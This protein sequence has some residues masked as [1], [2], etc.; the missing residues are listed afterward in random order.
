MPTQQFFEL[1]HGEDIIMCKDQREN[2]HIINNKYI[3][4]NKVRITLAET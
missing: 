3:L 1:Y 2:L 4:E